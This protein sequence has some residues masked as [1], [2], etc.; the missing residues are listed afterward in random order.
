MSHLNRGDG[1]F[2][3]VTVTLAKRDRPHKIVKQTISG[4]DGAFDL[5]RVQTGEYTLMAA[6][7]GLRDFHLYLKVTPGTSLPNE[8]LTVW[9]S[10]DLPKECSGSYA[11]L[12]LLPLGK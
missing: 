1:P 11:E 7:P 9:L 6:Y 3:E 12:G 5:G 2:S 10:A 4:K 8:I